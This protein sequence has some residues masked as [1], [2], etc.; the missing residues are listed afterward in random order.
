MCFNMLIQYL[1]VICTAESHEKSYTALFPR[2]LTCTHPPLRLP[3]AN[4]QQLCLQ[5]AAPKSRLKECFSFID[6]VAFV[7][8]TLEWNLYIKPWL[9][10]QIN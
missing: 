1:R 6:N 2:P 4:V 8:E 3:F 5:M 9:F 7:F 10:T